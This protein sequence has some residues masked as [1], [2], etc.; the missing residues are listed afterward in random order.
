[1]IPN[2]LSRPRPECIKNGSCHHALKNEIID[3][4]GVQP[5]PSDILAL[6]TRTLKGDT[7]MIPWTSLFE[8]DF[9][10]DFG[11]RRPIKISGHLDFKTIQRMGSETRATPCRLTNRKMSSAITKVGADNA[12]LEGHSTETFLT[13]RGPSPP[14]SSVPV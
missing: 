3:I 4:I 7:E 13:W 5:L 10:L 12:R 8:M 2:R 6:T 14:L 11:Q 1:M 9:I